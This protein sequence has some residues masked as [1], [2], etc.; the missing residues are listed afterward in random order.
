MFSKYGRKMKTG[1]PT[2]I[3]IPYQ[4]ISRGF[5]TRDVLEVAPD[6]LGKVLVVKNND[7]GY[8]RYA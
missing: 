4:R 1:S 2:D 7:Q 5:Y 3:E 8:F 6:L